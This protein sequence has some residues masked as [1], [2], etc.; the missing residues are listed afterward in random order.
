MEA[1]VPGGVEICMRT[2]TTSMGLVHAVAV[3]TDRP[4]A[5]S[6]AK[7][8]EEGAE[9]GG[10]EEVKDVREDEVP[11]VDVLMPFK[12]S[13]LRIRSINRVD[14]SSSS[15]ELEGEEKGEKGREKGGRMDNWGKSGT[16]EGH[17]APPSP[18]CRC[19][20]QKYRV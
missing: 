11:S 8:R 1:R 19:S 10:T 9:G 4:D 18:A 2:L 12:I 5:I 20:S 3:P 16:Q 7:T 6:W 17:T 14:P 15:D 13:I